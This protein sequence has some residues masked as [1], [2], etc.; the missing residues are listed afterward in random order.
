MTAPTLTAPTGTGANLSAILGTLMA[1]EVWPVDSGGGTLEVEYRAVPVA[2]VNDTDLLAFDSEAL[3]GRAAWLL[4]ATKN[5][6]AKQDLLSAHNAYLS[7][8]KGQQRPGGAFSL[9]RYDP[10]GEWMR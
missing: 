8:I 1:I 4:A 6:P 9:R 5:F 10:A 7:A 2:M 3:I